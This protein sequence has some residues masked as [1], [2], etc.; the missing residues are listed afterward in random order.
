M[1]S[2]CRW[3]VSVFAWAVASDGRPLLTLSSVAV[4]AT[5]R[6]GYVV[7]VAPGRSVF[8]SAWFLAVA[9]FCEILWLML[10]S[11]LF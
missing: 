2:D 3:V 11:T 1:G 7:L 9:A 8:W 6:F 4:A 10:T 5:L